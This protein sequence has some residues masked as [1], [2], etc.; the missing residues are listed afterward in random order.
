MY[1]KRLF[2]FPHAGGSASAFKSWCKTVPSDIEVVPVELPGRGMRFLESLPESFELLSQKMLVELNSQFDRPFFFFGHSMGG[3][4]AYLMA[5]N[6]KKNNEKSNLCGIVVSACRAPD[7]PESEPPIHHLPENLFLSELIK[8]DG[9]PNEVVQ[10][11]ELLDF[12]V[13]I[14][15]ADISILENH[16]WQDLDEKIAV[17]I[18]A[19]GGGEDSI[20]QYSMDRWRLKTSSTFRNRSFS[21][22]HFFLKDSEAEVV[23]SL[24]FDL[25]NLSKF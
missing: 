6:I 9:I 11:K 14:I 12:V 1:K 7:D 5:I 17:P 22:G 13:P 19:Y 20:S 3:L 2:C 8:F 4:L 23:K 16:V 25:G 21:G 10:D 15:R 24:A 18:V